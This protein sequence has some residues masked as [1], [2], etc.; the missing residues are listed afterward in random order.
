M[1]VKNHLS[2]RSVAEPMN[3]RPFTV[4]DLLDLV[5]DVQ[6]LRSLG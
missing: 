2:R 1:K 4:R 3:L 5:G 6:L